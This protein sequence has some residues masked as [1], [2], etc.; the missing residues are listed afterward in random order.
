MLTKIDNIVMEVT[1]VHK[2]TEACNNYGLS[3]RAGIARLITLYGNHPEELHALMRYMDDSSQDRTLFY[4]ARDE[5]NNQFGNSN[6]SS[7]NNH[8]GEF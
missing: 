3:F 6:H 4:A 7:T 5:D 8:A 1:R 2:F